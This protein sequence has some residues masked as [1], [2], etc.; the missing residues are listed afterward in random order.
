[1]Q[2]LLSYS[3]G[4]GGK[5]RCRRKKSDCGVGGKLRCRRKKSDCGVG[6]KLRCRRKFSFE[7][8]NGGE[9]QEGSGAESSSG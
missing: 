4:V 8:A 2:E 1:M 5:L 3:F 6:G 9:Y 7:P